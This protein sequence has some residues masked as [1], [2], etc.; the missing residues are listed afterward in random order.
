MKMACTMENGLESALP[1]LIFTL[2][3]AVCQDGGFHRILFSV[4]L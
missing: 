3:S 1:A 2:N 4:Q